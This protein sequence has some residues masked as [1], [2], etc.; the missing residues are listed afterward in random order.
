MPGTEKLTVKVTVAAVGLGVGTG[1]ILPAVGKG[2]NGACVGVRVG[3]AV[4]KL[5][6]VRSVG[7]KPQNS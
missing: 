2:E 6:G 3:F 4:G 5:V 7:V 1:I